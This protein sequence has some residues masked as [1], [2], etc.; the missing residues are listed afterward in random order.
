MRRA[1]SLTLGEITEF[2]LCSASARLQGFD[3]GDFPAFVKLVPMADAELVRLQ[4]EGYAY[5]K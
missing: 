4:G 5:L 1:E 2:R 3:A